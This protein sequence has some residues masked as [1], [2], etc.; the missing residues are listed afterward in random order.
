MYIVV[1]FISVAKYLMSLQPKYD[2]SFHDAHLLY[3]STYL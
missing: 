1:M 3:K 2:I